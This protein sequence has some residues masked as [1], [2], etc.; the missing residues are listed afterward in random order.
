MQAEARI[1]YL[2]TAS[3]S[4][5]Q[6]FTPMPWTVQLLFLLVPAVNMINQELTIFTAHKTIHMP[7]HVRS[8]TQCEHSHLINIQTHAASLTGCWYC[9]ACLH[10]PWKPQKIRSLPYQVV[11]SDNVHPLSV[12]CDV[13]TVRLIYLINAIFSESDI[14]WLSQNL[15]EIVFLL[16]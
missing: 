8:C 12:K 14:L 1:W 3:T 16:D 11:V 9:K 13:F 10:C 15:E 2:F 4:G 7:A 5:L 6:R